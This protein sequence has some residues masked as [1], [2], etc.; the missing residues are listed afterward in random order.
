MA[1]L[2]KA[3]KFIDF[4]D[5]GRTPGRLIAKS[6]Q[7]TAVTPIHVTSMFVLAGLAAILS[8]LNGYYF[9]G[10]ILLIVKSALDAADGELSRLKQ[11]P[12]HTGRYYDSISDIILNFLFL[13]TFWKVT[14]GNFLHTLFAFIG[15]QLQ[16]TV[17]NFYYVILRNNANGD[18]TSRIF[19]NEAPTAL[20]GEKQSTVNFV[21]KLYTLLYSVFD[22]TIY[23][24]DSSAANCAPFP[25]WFMTLVSIFGLGFQLLIMSFL[26][27]INKVEYIIP[28][29]IGYSGFIFVF[30]GLRKVLFIPQNL[31]Q[32]LN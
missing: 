17:Y 4:S 16:G 23:A 13:L 9:I 6:F 30:I 2:P 20:K 18:T 12:S 8:I 19:E 22:K 27:M 15:L 1:K 26:L 25:K 32:T 21:Y 10:G 7:N 24:M 3:Y 11:T 14:D 5:Y 28:F 31:E 29:F